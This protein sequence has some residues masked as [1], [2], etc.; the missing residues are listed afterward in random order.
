MDLPSDLHIIAVEI[1]EDREFS[2]NLTPALEKKFTEILNKITELIRTI[3][4]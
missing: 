4:G 3:T 1:I 2:E